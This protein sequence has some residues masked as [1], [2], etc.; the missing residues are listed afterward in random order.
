M[1]THLFV[2]FSIVFFKSITNC[3]SYNKTI[4]LTWP[5]NSKTISWGGAQRFEFTKSSVVESPWLAMNEYASAEHAG[6]HMDAPYHFVEDGWKVGQIPLSYLT[7]PGFKIDLSH[8]TM[9][10]G[11]GA[12]LEVRHLL[13]W[14]RRHGPIPYR[15][16]M[17]VYFNWGRQYYNNTLAYLGGESP[18]EYKFPGISAEAAVWIRDSRK[19][20]GVGIDTASID[21]NNSTV[22]HRILL[23]NKMFNLENVKIPGRELPARGFRLSVTPMLIEEGTGA[24]TRIIA[25]VY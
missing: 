19:V 1:K 10:H 18:A 20:I 9:E 2:T 6:T 12:R 5:F 11:S 25:Y 17:L 4:D 24:P 3:D 8:E 23:P 21:P 13:E 22:A 7:A 15:S 14:Q 16:I